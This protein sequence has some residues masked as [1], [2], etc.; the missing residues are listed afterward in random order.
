MKKIITQDE[1]K[2]I[3]HYNPDTG[4]FTYTKDVSNHRKKGSI[5]GYKHLGYINI[6][7]KEKGY[8][9]HRLAWLYFYG[10]FPKKDIDHINNI[11]DD[12]RIKNLRE[13]DRFINSQNFKVAR[14]DNKTG[15]LGVCIQHGKFKATIFSNK[16]SIH[17]GYFDKAIDAHKEYLKA[18]RMLH[19]GCMI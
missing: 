8:K 16:K 13:A 2:E 9:A 14:K 5:A 17:L 3:L 6:E 1:L 7:I 4:I 18:K 11:R 19:K 10:E 12:N 15:Y